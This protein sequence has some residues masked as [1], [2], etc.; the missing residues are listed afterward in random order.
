MQISCF[1]WRKSDY[2]VVN[3]Y[4][5]HI[6]IEQIWEVVGQGREYPFY[7]IKSTQEIALP[8]SYQHEE[9]K[10]IIDIFIRKHTNTGGWTCPAEEMVDS[11]S[12]GSVEQRYKSEKEGIT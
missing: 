6:L 12:N 2:G 1:S 7:E 10:Q 3:R 5:Y 11:E 8:E 9:Y 4:A